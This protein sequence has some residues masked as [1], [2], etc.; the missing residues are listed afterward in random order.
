MSGHDLDRVDPVPYIS[1]VVD[2]LLAAGIGVTQWHVDHDDTNYPLTAAIA[3]DPAS[4]PAWDG[5]TLVWTEGNGWGYGPHRP[6]G[7]DRLAYVLAIG[8]SGLPEPAEV[9]AEVQRTVLGDQDGTDT[10]HLLYDAD[11]IA[12]Q[13]RR[14]S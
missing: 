12:D 13:L 5:V 10:Y 1:A 2:A 3:L 6:D 8:A 4:A 7:Y 14:W 11:D 9:V